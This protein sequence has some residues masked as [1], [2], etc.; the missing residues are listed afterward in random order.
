MKKT[1][2]IFIALLLFFV[3]GCSNKEVI[4]HNYTYTGENEFWMA[5]YNIICTKTFTDK[6]HYK[7]YRDGVFTA[8]YKKDLSKLAPANYLEMS[9]ESSIVKGEMQEYL[10]GSPHQKTYSINDG[11][12]GGVFEKKD[13]IIKVTINVDGKIQSLELKNVQ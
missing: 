8:T 11:G 4:I 7:Y 13:E 9:Y 2:I 5:E 10:N 6:E 1:T 3:A 12:S